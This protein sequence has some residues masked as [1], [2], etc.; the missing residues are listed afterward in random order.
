MAELIDGR[1]GESSIHAQRRVRREQQPRAAAPAERNS[2]CGFTVR[3]ESDDQIS[4]VYDLELMAASDH[5]KMQWISVILE[6]V[7]EQLASTQPRARQ[8]RDV[9][10]PAQLV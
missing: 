5:L 8:R 10:T 3:V 1:G 2:K 4:D 6:V 9:R 7:K